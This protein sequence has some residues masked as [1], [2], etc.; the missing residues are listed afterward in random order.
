MEISQKAVLLILAQFY[1]KLNNKYIKFITITNNPALKLYKSNA[2]AL[3]TG[4]IGVFCENAVCISIF[5]A[6][7]AIGIADSRNKIAG[8]DTAKKENDQQ[9][10]KHFYVIA[11]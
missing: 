4:K 2:V 11:S 10:R 9:Q 5:S 1:K 3:S 6:G 8:H 7:I